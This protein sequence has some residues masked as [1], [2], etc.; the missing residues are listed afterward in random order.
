MGRNLTQK[1]PV[2]KSQEQSVRQTESSFNIFA[3]LRAVHADRQRAGQRLGFEIIA[4]AGHVV[5][6]DGITIG[7]NQAGFLGVT[8][9][10]VV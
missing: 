4:E 5:G 10:V 2:T 9:Q 8:T 1:N 6:A 7:L 3:L